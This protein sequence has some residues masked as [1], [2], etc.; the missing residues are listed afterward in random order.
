MSRPIRHAIGPG[1]ALAALA[2][3]QPW[4]EQRMAL[5]MAVELPLLFA[6]GWAAAGR[7]MGP[8]RMQKINA[9]GLTG[10]TMAMAIS[11]LW[12]LPVSL[13]AAVLNP[14]VGL[15]KVATVLLAG[16][17]T[18]LSLRA[19][20]K[21][22]QAFFVFNWVWMTGV[23]GAL[24]Q[25]APERLCSTYLQGDQALAGAGL[26]GLAIAAAAAWLLVSFRRP[27]GPDLALPA[28]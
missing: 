3:L 4:L 5:H 14:L 1:L 25:Q 10:L 27:A 15:A 16:W 6:I 23:A 9:Q 17:L 2:P 11:V 8:L 21:A 20:N 28:R 26:V 22:V 13:D 19:A 12:M 7:S 18:R 24:Y